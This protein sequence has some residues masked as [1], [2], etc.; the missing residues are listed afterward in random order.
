MIEKFAHKRPEVSAGAWIHHSAC[1]MG[2]VSIGAD[3]SVW[4]G[5]VI[6][7]DVDRIEVGRG[8]NIQDLAVLH[9]NGNRPV[10][11]GEGVTVGHSAIIHGSTVGAHSLVGMGAVVM[12][13]EIGEYCLIAAGAVVTPGSRIPPRSMVM[14]APARVK[15]SLTEEECAGLVRSEKD[16]IALAGIYR[17][18]SDR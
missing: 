1:V 11:L 18:G 12:D 10:I 17:T 9:P 4:P 8:S 6:R 7:G 13:S 16:Y 5:A 3:V 2:E 15:R 14:G